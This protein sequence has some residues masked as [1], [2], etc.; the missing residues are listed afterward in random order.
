MPS[1]DG[2]PAGI[3][4]FVAAAS[5]ASVCASGGDC[6]GA[7]ETVQLS[8]T[9]VGPG[10]S[11]AAPFERLFFYYTD[12]LGALRMLGAFRSLAPADTPQGRTWTYG[13]TL[14]APALGG[15]L[16]APGG[17][18]TIYAV[19]VDSQGDALLAATAVLT[20]R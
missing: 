8:A 19:G 20:V 6:G 12:R 13:A 10:G 1:G 3:R 9:V 2:L 14:D 18:T 11:F 5:A 15:R 16:P 7:P 17:T 4:S